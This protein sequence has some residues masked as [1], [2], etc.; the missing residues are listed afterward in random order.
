MDPRPDYKQTEVGIIPVDWE[1]KTLQ[2]GIRLLSGHHVLAQ[3]CNTTGHGTRYITGPA[4]F[5]DGIIQNSRF[6]NKPTTICRRGD[7]LVTVK[8]SGAGTIILADG[9]YCISRQLMAVRVTGWDTGY[10]YE[11][12]RRNASL[13]GAAATGLIPGL[14]RGDILNKRIPLP[15]FPEQRA[16]AAAL[17]DVDDLISGL[18]QL[19]VKKHDIKQA[20]M[21]QLLTGKTRLPEFSGKWEIK[22]IGEKIDLLT[23]FPF[24][25]NSYSKGGIRL[26]RG[27]NVK[28]GNTDWADEITQYWPE[29]TQELGR[30][31]LHSG[32]L[33]IAMDGSL[34]GRSFARLTNDD[35]PAL[36]LQRVARIRS[37]SI[38]LAYL[39]Q[40]IGSDLFIKY[41]DSVKT[42]TAIPHISA[43]DI[44]R[45]SI[46]IP[47][48]F[49]EQ[50]AIATVLSDMDAE[51]SALEARRDKSRALKQG[52]MQEL[53][54]G[55]IRLV[56]P[57]LKVAAAA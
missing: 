27:S 54:T 37:T 56:Q 3:H 13:F 55:R 15:S 31:E 39:A 22:P 10:V 40:F 42:V 47:P 11:C 7:I 35:L 32:D 20:A 6:T 25:S 18:D 53:M 1:E 4:D 50:T 30:Y 5:P 8:G 9:E 46:P 28:R 19:I 52:M 21:Q 17:S 41:C 16:I 44:R 34:V 23:G 49:S 2:E 12:L 26:L 38:D 45:F 33:V 43:E 51:V 24:P 57:K 36:L 48:T 14:S 29:V